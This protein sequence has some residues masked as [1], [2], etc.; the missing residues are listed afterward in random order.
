MEFK[1]E[2]DEYGVQWTDFVHVFE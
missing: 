1:W 2:I